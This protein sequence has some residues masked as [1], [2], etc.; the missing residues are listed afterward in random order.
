MG[1]VFHQMDDRWA[2]LGS[3]GWQEWSKFGMVE[4]GVDTANPKS[5]T[6]DLNWKN[7]WHGA[8]GAQYQ[9]SEAWRYSF[10]IAYDSGFHGNGTVSP[11][12][13]ADSAWRFG[14][15]AH[16]QSSKDF[17]WDVAAE[18]LYGGSLNVNSRSNLPVAIGGKG[19]VVGSYDNL[20]MVFLS[21]SADWK[22]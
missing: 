18:Y 19:D 17:T 20:G 7:T 1:S 14:V 13:P 22:F 8:V 3:V 2:L 10:G 5:I 6:T 12:V 16:N 9:A 4:V 21:A 15:G 11:L